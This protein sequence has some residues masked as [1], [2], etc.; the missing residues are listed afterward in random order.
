MLLEFDRRLGRPALRRAAPR[1]VFS[2]TAFGRIRRFAQL[3]SL[4]RRLALGNLV[5]SPPRWARFSGLP[6]LHLASGHECAENHFRRIFVGSWAQIGIFV[7]LVF[8]FVRDASRAACGRRNV[9]WMPRRNSLTL[10]F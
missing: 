7:G 6:D 4:H 5:W 9:R 2:L 8:W 1:F 10:L 3:H